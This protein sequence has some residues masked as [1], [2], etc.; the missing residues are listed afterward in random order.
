MAAIETI[1]A[2]P[3]AITVSLEDVDWAKEQAS[4][5]DIGPIYHAMK[6]STQKPANTAFITYSKQTKNLLEQWQSLTMQ[7]DKLYRKW[8]NNRNEILRLQLIVP[9]KLQGAFIGACHTGMTGGHLG[10]KKTVLQVQ[11]RG[12]FP[13]GRAKSY[14]WCRQCK[15][16]S[17]YFRGTLKHQAEMQPIFTGYPMERLGID[18]CGPFPESYYG[19]TYILTCTDYFTQWTE[20]VAIAEKQAKTIAKALVDNVF[21]RL[22]CPWELVSD[23][24]TEFDNKFLRELCDRFHIH[25]VRTT[26]YHPNSNGVAERIHRTLNSLLGK[27]T[28]DQQTD[29]TDH[30]QPLMSAYRAAVHNSTGYSPNLLMLGR[31]INTPLDILIKTPNETTPT[32]DDYVSRLTKTLHECHKEVRIA[33]QTNTNINKRHYDIR[34]KRKHQ[35]NVGDWVWFYKPRH[36][37]G[38]SQKWERLYSGPY[39]I[40][41]KF[42]NVNVTIQQKVASQSVVTHIDKLKPYF[43]ETPADFTAPVTPTQLE[44]ITN[45]PEDEIQRTE[46]EIDTDETALKEVDTNTVLL[47]RHVRLPVKYNDYDLS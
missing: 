24:G 1:D 29:W 36:I 46:R 41:N 22:G 45:G 7:E 28:S 18:L 30:L 27:V 8:M 2:S 12:C 32:A 11:R 26:A 3:T 31:E 5:P 10:P 43:G 25:K 19:K 34:V 4:D 23:Q 9:W 6:Q 47:R 40:M 37:S 38:R 17:T 35:F 33:L 14:R 42:N 44:T 16:C 21:S 20:C 39:R 15:P 13:G